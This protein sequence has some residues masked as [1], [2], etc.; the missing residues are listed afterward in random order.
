VNECM[1]H[2]NPKDLEQKLRTLQ[3]GLAKVLGPGKTMNFRNQTVDGTVINPLVAA[4][5]A[6]LG[7]VDTAS[8]AWHQAVKNRDAGVPGIET[9]IADLALGADYTWGVGSPECQE[10]GFMPR[11]QPAPLTSEQNAQKA[12]KARA[13]RQARGTLGPKAR[14]SVKGAVSPDQGSATTGTKGP[15]TGGSAPAGK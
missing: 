7:S 4:A 14:K 6:L 1:S 9:L 12:A 10:L 15:A 5:L 2:D 3:A 13:T 11:K 8:I